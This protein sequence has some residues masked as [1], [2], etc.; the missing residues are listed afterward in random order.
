LTL[1][2]EE[3]FKKDGSVLQEQFGHGI[4]WN[5]TIWEA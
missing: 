1:K 3:A 2:V 5:G 4:G